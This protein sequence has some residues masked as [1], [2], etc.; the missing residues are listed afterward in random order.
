MIINHFQKLFHHPQLKIMRKSIYLVCFLLFIT[1]FSAAYSQRY[2]T[3]ADTVKLNKEY[4]QLSNDIA[5]LT[6]QL[7]IAQNDLPGIQTKA[8]NAESDAQ[9][10]AASSSDQASKAT[11]GSV[12]DAKRAKRRAKT[13]YN[14]AKDARSANENVSDQD[15]KIARLSKQLKKKQNR[16]TEVESMRAEINAK[17]SVP[18]QQ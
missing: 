13:A 7:Q 14:E 11:N 3:A 9:N 5:G 8:N 1:G 17:Y 2:R 15:D 4:T 10:A 18:A 12:K 6:A 16:L